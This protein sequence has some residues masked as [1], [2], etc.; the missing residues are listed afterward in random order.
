[1]K[2]MFAL[3]PVCVLSA[4]ADSGP[5]KIGKDAYS[6]T[7]RVAFTGAASAQA[8]AITEAGKFCSTQ[9]KEMVMRQVSNNECM[10]HGGCGEAYIEFLC[11]N[12]DDPRYLNA[13]K[14]DVKVHQ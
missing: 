12:A 3:V 2:V 6:I 9:H 4:C 10:L 13:E 11:V 14:T 7:T 5:V 1:M 8:E